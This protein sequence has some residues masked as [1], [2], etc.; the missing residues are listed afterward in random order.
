MPGTKF[1]ADGRNM[2]TR[3]H[4]VRRDDRPARAGRH[5]DDVRIADSTGGSIHGRGRQLELVPC[6]G[7]EGFVVLWYRAVHPHAAELAHGCQRPQ[8][9]PCLTAAAHDADSLGAWLCSASAAGVS[10]ERIVASE[11]D[12]WLA[13]RA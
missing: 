8:L 1:R 11:F 4:V 10:G 6:P 7:S 2:R 9:C 13:A 12:V 3:A 5:Q